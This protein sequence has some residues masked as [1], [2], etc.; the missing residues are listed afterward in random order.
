MKRAL[1]WFGIAAVLVFVLMI[2]RTFTFSGGGDEVRPV[3][4]LEIDEM[5]VAE[6]LAGG[7]RIPTIAYSDRSLMD[8]EAFDSFHDYLQTNYPKVFSF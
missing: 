7:L 6:R 3:P 5:A 8:S 1:K 2:Y 4:L